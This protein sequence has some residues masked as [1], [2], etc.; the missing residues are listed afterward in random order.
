EIRWADQAQTE[1][2]Y[3]VERSVNNGA[4]E[5]IGTALANATSFALPAGTS[6]PAG[7]TMKFRVTAV[8]ANGTAS[9]EATVSAPPANAL[10]APTGLVSL[11]V[12]STQ[13]NRPRV[14]LNWVDASI[15]ENVFDVYRKV[16]GSA[17]AAILVGSV[18]SAA[19]ATTGQVLS[20]VDGNQNS[21]A[22]RP[23]FGTS[24]DYTVV[25]RK[26]SAPTASS[27]A[28]AALTVRIGATGNAF[29]TTTPT[30]GA[31][32]AVR[33]ATTGTNRN[34]DTVILNWTEEATNSN[35]V[36]SV[37]YRMCAVAN[38]SS[39]SCRYTVGDARYWGPWTTAALGAAGSAANSTGGSFSI[40]NQSVHTV[41]AGQTAAGRPAQFQ[42]RAQNAI[43]NGGWSTP[44]TDIVL[45]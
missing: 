8:G 21:A 19:A 37:Q 22:Q 33:M 2:Q 16:T 11:G 27:A 39:T 23:A 9:S 45:P 36:Y 3:L 31:V 20:F 42:I 29:G 43:G 1:Y 24:Y 41:Q 40:A 35:T 6:L 14:T 32:N 30:L 26:T 18:N 7:T 4:W 44:A 17:Q 28:S 5:S 10:P 12:T 25:A 34:R 38:T 13:N 15:G